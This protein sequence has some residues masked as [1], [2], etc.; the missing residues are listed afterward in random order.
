[1]DEG[2]K[3]LKQG[4]KMAKGGLFS[5]SDP[6]NAEK[7]YEKARKKFRFIKPQTEESVTLY[8]ESLES[9]S[10][11]R[12]T[13]RLNNS[14]AAAM[15][16]AARAC[17]SAF[18]KDPKMEP[19]LQ[20]IPHFLERGAYF[21]RLNNQYDKASK[22]LVQS[23]KHIKEVDEAV[24]KLELA[25][26]IQEEENR[27]VT[28]HEFFDAAVKWCCDH[29]QWKTAD[30]FL[31]R[32][33]VMFGKDADKFDKRIWRNICSKM[34]LQF[35]LKD[36]K[37]AQSMYYEGVDQWGQHSKNDEHGLC[38][39]FLSVFSSADAEG[40]KNMQ[41]HGQLGIYFIS[42]I[43]RIARKLDMKDIRPLVSAEDLEQKE[44]DAV[45]EE[46]VQQA[47]EEITD[48]HLVS[49]VKNVKLDEDTG[50]PD[51]MMDM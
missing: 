27:Y 2:R 26:E 15:E 10:A 41:E 6:D 7:Q 21:Y 17:E 22:L 24:S 32:Q 51:L 13:M 47:L 11:V 36:V 44:N 49:D 4:H 39:Q 28:C 40:L 16:E 3:C 35:H 12:E 8:L 23:A 5:K 20:R 48:E 45:K 30:E 29:R 25:V 18:D 46:E 50:A 14:A 38:E 43:S 34:V 31:N 33:I 42:S 37:M 1:M 9:L 19:F